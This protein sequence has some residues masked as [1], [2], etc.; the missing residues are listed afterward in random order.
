[1]WF[2]PRICVIV[3]GVRTQSVQRARN[4][5]I[6]FRSRCILC[7]R[8]PFLHIDLFRLSPTVF[9]VAYNTSLVCPV[10]RRQTPIRQCAQ[11]GSR[12]QTGFVHSRWISPLLSYRSESDPRLTAVSIFLSRFDIFFTDPAR[13]IDKSL[14]APP[15]AITNISW[16]WN[17][18]QIMPKTNR[19]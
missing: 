1:M 19:N 18:L 3:N 7:V 4:V 16:K 11:M 14:S 13:S 9:F 2:W 17:S 5:I 12:C 15:L 8:T 6:T 10:W